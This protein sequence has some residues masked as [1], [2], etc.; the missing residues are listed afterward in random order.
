MEL[1]QQS[2]VAV[3]QRIPSGANGFDPMGR[4]WSDVNCPDEVLQMFMTISA[5][6]RG[7]RSS[8]SGSELTD[9]FLILSFLHGS[10]DPSGRGYPNCGILIRHHEGCKHMTCDGSITMRYQG[11]T[12][13]YGIEDTVVRSRKTPGRS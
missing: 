7:K 10:R 13:T 2:Q 8:Q 11:I 12:A 6:Q 3:D 9:Y 4:P 1:S 5:G